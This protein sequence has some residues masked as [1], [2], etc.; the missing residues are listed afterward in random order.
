MF[1]HDHR[2]T[3]FAL[4]GLEERSECLGLALGDAGGRFVE[5]EDLRVEGEEAG[6]FHDASGTG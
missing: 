6:Q 5:A 1:D 2:G 3:E 4:D